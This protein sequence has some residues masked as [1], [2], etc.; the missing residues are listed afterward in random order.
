MYVSIYVCMYACMFVCMY[1]CMYVCMY[2][3]EH[4]QALRC[5]PFVCDVDYPRLW[6]GLL[7]P[8]GRE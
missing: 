4:G 5:A 1:A 6:T 7:A 8:L 3:G 2:V